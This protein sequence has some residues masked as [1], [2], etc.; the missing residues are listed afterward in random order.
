MPT[1]AQVFRTELALLITER[2]LSFNCFVLTVD[3]HVSTTSP[4][5]S[6]VV[7][8][9]CVERKTSKVTGNYSVVWLEDAGIV[10]AVSCDVGVRRVAGDYFL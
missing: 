6:N 10:A 9:G 1:I 4:S 3:I 2:R 8:I 7:N 5:G